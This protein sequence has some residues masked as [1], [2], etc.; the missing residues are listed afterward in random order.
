MEKEKKKRK[1]KGVHFVLVCFAFPL[2]V[3]ILLLEDSLILDVQ[4]YFILPSSYFIFS[5][6]GY[7]RPLRILSVIF[8]CAFL[9]HSIT[10]IFFSFPVSNSNQINCSPQQNLFCIELYLCLFCHLSSSSKWFL[11]LRFVVLSPVLS[12]VPLPLFSACEE[13]C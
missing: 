7:L 11:A 9:I 12:Y 8:D 5:Y 6:S 10:D 4:L 13:N 1:Q 2:I 3:T